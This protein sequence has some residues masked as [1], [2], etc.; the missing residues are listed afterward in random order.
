VVNVEEAG[1]V[2]HTMM[3]LERSRG[4]LHRQNPPHELDHPATELDVPII[5]R[6]LSSHI[7]LLI[8]ETHFAVPHAIEL[9]KPH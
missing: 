4:I 9:G 1:R 5:E 7:Y 6:R 8:C 2:A 3:F